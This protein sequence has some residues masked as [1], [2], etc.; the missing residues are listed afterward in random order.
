MDSINRYIDD[1]LIISD[2]QA[3][4]KDDALRLLV[5]RIFEKRSNLFPENFTSSDLYKEV[6][7][8]EKIQTTGLGSGI[9]FPHTRIADLNDFAL[10]IGI[11]KKPIDWQSIDKKPCHVICL[12]VSP[13]LKPYLIL[14]IMA[15]L[16]KFMGRP[17]NI[18]KITSGL[19]PQQ[20]AELIKG[21]ALETGKTVMSKDI[22]RPVEK[23]VTLET[24]IEKTA[25]IMHLNRLDILPVID[26]ENT[27][28]GEISCLDIFKFG[29]PDFF[30]QLRTI[31]FMKNLDPFEK[32]FKFQK[33]LK[34]KDVYSETTSIISKDTTLMEIIFEMT[35]KNK[36]KLFVVDSGKLIG[37]IDRFS[38]ID[39]I[40]FF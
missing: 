14:Q 28:L 19:S 30:S 29:I 12:M 36:L 8:R 15:V 31:S 9:A 25:Q 3:E 4:T 7:K 39:K 34:V 1:S 5:N 17:N 23:C 18:E 33:G 11:S 35:T 13:L 27:L 26:D 21:S 16:A 24:S 32:Y 22:M 10:A 40:L 6:I 20:I 38:I 2:L 37:I